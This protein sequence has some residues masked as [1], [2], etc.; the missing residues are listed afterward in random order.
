MEKVLTREYSSGIVDERIS[1]VISD[2]G[3][4]IRSLIA[5]YVL[6]GVEEGMVQ[7]FW[8]CFADRYKEEI[9]KRVGDK[10]GLVM[11][12][13]IKRFEQFKEHCC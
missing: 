13:L 10:E 5:R 8:Q 2:G 9:K 6:A 7:R 1:K 3:K 11:E 12:V 4:G